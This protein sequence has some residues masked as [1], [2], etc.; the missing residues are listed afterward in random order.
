[1]PNTKLSRQKLAN[2]YHYSKYGYLLVALL[3]ALAGDLLFTVT[4]YRA[5]NARRVDIELVAAYA[6]T[7]QSQSYA[8]TALEAGI[9]YEIARDAAAGMD[10]LSEEYEPA[11]QKVEFSSISYDPESSGE[12]SYYGSQKYLVTLAAQEGDIFILSRSLMDELAQDG[13]LTDL[14]PYIESGLLN[15][16]D[17]DLSRGTYPEFVEEGEPATGRECVYALPADSLTGLYSAMSY[18]VTGKYM[19]II[20]YSQNPDTA[21]VVMQSLID[22][23]EAPAEEEVAE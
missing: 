2:H 19:V 13:S 9:A 1:M 3:A 12:E 6:D 20:G 23:F 4:E 15:P 7:S 22:Q 11:L 5:P 8:Q 16:G 21:A 17:R 18:D 14:T 10:T